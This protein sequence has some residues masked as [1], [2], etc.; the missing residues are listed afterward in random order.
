MYCKVYACR[1]VSRPLKIQRNYSTA[2]GRTGDLTAEHAPK[3]RSTW[4]TKSAR[5]AKLQA[6]LAASRRGNK[7]LQDLRSIQ[8]YALG[9]LDLAHALGAMLK[10]TF[11]FILSSCRLPNRV[12][13]LGRFRNEKIQFPSSENMILGACLPSQGDPNGAFAP[14]PPLTRGG[15]LDWNPRN[16]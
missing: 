4:T 13:L 8:R 12:Q 14:P 16:L 11:L 6:T 15:F 5:I 1:K 10:A 7:Q 9:T 2:N 3:Q